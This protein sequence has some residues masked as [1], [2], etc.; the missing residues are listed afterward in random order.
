V[1]YQQLLSES[2]GKLRYSYPLAG[3]GGRNAPSID[4]FSLAVE[5]RGDLGERFTVST[6]DEATVSNDDAL[7]TMRRTGFTPRADFELELTR[8]PSDDDEHKAAALRLAQYEG[9]ADQARFVMLRWLPDLD[10]SKYAAP[11]A[12]VVVVVDT[13]AFGDDAEHRSRIAVAEALLRS[14]SSEDHFALMAADLTAEV[15]YPAEGHPAGNLSPATPEAITEA[16]SARW[17]SD[18]MRAQRSG[19]QGIG[20]PVRS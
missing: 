18:W 3:P 11:R 12:D 10:F 15:L 1:R 19:S 16:L 14:L 7:I 8:K 17:K 4:E 6:L 13:S 5:L 9:G 20:A 2:Q